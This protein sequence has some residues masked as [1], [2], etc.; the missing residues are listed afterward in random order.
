[1]VSP[2]ICSEPMI[3][4]SPPEKATALITSLPATKH[5]HLSFSLYIYVCMYVL[6]VKG[7]TLLHVFSFYIPFLFIFCPVRNT[8]LSGGCDDKIWFLSESGQCWC[9]RILAGR[10]RWHDDVRDLIWWIHL[11]LGFLGFDLSFSIPLTSNATVFAAMA[12]PHS[13]PWLHTDLSLTLSPYCLYFDLSRLWMCFI[14]L[15]APYKYFFYL[16]K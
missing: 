15:R 5:N 7:L 10:F 2:I 4:P 13:L 3:S 8:Q 14:D 11:G 6:C 9:A 12:V 16:G 1:M